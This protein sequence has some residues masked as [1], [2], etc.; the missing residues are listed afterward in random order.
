MLNIVYLYEHFLS[1]TK[2]KKM[3]PAR[4][5][6]KHKNFKSNYDLH[7]VFYYWTNVHVS[8]C[9][10]EPP[11]FVNA[12]LIC[13]SRF[14]YNQ[15]FHVSNQGIYHNRILN[16]NGKYKSRTKC[17]LISRQVPHHVR[18]EL[19]VSPPIKPFWKYYVLTIETGFVIIN[20]QF[21]QSNLF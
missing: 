18:I 1:V 13:F 8:G 6:F 5:G 4:S 21:N 20:W 11:C 14:E 16:R 9:V 10:V 2:K 7:Q 3:H 19:L 15:I 17:A 12:Y